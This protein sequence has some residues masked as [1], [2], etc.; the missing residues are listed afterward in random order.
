MNKQALL[1]SIADNVRKKH[2]WKISQEKYI[3][4]FG[5]LPKEFLA[6]RLAYDNLLE[7]TKQFKICQ[8]VLS[9]V[10]IEIKLTID[11]CIAWELNLDKWE[12]ARA[13]NIIPNDIKKLLKDD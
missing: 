3:K 2:P 4:L 5:E 11:E 10:K 1:Q 7:K 9:E 6:E 8:L 13:H 12:E